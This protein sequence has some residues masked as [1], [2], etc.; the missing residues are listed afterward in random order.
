[1]AKK[2]VLICIILMIMTGQAFSQKANFEAAER[3][4]PENLQ[5]MVGDRNLQPNWI[6]DSDR[7]W[8]SYKTSDGTNYYVV[9]AAR[10]TKNLLFDRE[11][12][13]SELTRLTN[14]PVN[15][16]ELSLTELT[17]KDNN[18]I[19]FE[20]EDA[21]YEHVLNS[22]AVTKVKDKD[23]EAPAQRW[24]Q[25]SP[26]SLWVVFAKNHNLFLMKIGDPDS[27]EFQLTTDG[28]KWYSFGRNNS[29]TSKTKRL[30]S[31]AVWFKDSKKLYVNRTDSRKVGDLWVIQSTAQPRPTLETYKYPLPGDKYINQDELIVFD[32]E[33]KSR[34]DVKIEKWKD[35]SIERTYFAGNRSDIMYFVRRDRTWKDIELCEANTETGEVRALVSEHIEPYFHTMMT[36]FA[37]INNGEELIW[38]SERDGW[39]HLYLYD[40]DGNLK[41]R[42]TEGAFIVGGISRIDT[43]GRMLYLEAYGKED[44]VDPYYNMYYKVGFDGGNIQLLT[45]EN[46]THDFDMSKSNRYFVDTFSRVDLPSKSV[47]RDNRGNIVLE[48][49]NV[50]ITKLVEAG[51]KSAEPFKV[52]AADGITDIYGVMWKPFDFDPEKKYPIIAYCYPGPQAEPVTKTFLE[53]RNQRVHNIPLSQLGFVVVAVGQRGGSPQRSKWYHNYGYDNLRDYPLADNKAALEQLA[54][55]HSFIDIDKVG[56]YGRSGGGFMSTAAILVYPDFYKVAVSSCGNH[57]NNIYNIWWSESHHGVKEVTK[58]T[59]DKETGEETEEKVFE[60]KIPTNQSLAKNL[61]GHLLLYHGEVDNNVHPANTI[62]VVNELIKAGKRFDLKIFPGKRHTYGDYT[63]YIERMMWYYFAEHL[64]GDHRTNV[65]IKIHDKK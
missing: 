48:L 14:K 62:R 46:A 44:G 32:T 19:T 24:K 33:T 26:D 57:D 5:K 65:D 17:F 52:K 45:E 35:Q 27:T 55:R 23:K 63:S 50:D 54:A 36:T 37:S 34:V 39:A 28:E 11:M 64:L 31:S 53:I 8:Y 42:I 41:S 60:S 30:R 59:K 15:S 22:A 25:F 61:K 47:L 56:I 12:I 1:M 58:K 21:V 2:L 9:D 29:D 16:K 51:W 18:T 49:E 7:F 3:F 6:E 10:K 38:L 13:A 43:T 40:G 20:V 4:A